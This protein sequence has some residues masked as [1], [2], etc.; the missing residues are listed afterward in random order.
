MREMQPRSDRSL[1]SPSLDSWL[2]PDG[3]LL[4]LYD[5]VGQLRLTR[6][7]DAERR[8]D[9]ANQRAAAAHQRIEDAIR[10]AQTSAEKLRSLGIDLDQIIRES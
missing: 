6:A 7:G 8:A 5:N 10:Q 4:R 3:A 1:W 2:V 9:A